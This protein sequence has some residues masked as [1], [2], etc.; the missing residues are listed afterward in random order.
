[1]NIYNKNAAFLSVP[2]TGM[3][4]ETNEPMKSRDDL[5]KRIVPSSSKSF[6][7]FIISKVPEN[8]KFQPF[9]FSYVIPGTTNKVKM[10]V[11]YDGQDPKTQRRLSV[12]VHHKDRD[13]LTSEYIL[14]G[15][16]KEIMSY[17]QDDKNYD[18]LRKTINE[19]CDQTEAYYNSL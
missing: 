8:G 7:E 13:R 2:F 16:K 5:L 9:S 3:P 14:K 6:S 1:M 11:E 12:G 18:F 19:L 15:T 17:L 4:R 10:T